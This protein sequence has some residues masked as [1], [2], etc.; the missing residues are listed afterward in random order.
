MD[1]IA[2]GATPGVLRGSGATQQYIELGVVAGPAQRHWSF[3]CKRWQ[4]N[5]FFIN[6]HLMREGLFLSWT[7]T[8]SLC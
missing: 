2:R 5:F 3:M 4:L 6:C 1:F 8:V 7:S